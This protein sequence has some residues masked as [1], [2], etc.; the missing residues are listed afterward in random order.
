[1]DERQLYAPRITDQV[2]LLERIANGL[3]EAYRSDLE[4]ELKH[5]FSVQ[6]L[7]R[8]S[9]ADSAEDHFYELRYNENDFGIILPIQKLALI[10]NRY[11]DVDESI[12]HLAKE[13]LEKRGYSVSYEV[14]DMYNLVEIAKQKRLNREESEGELKLRELRESTHL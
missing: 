12:F 4:T 6:S 8:Y 7:T 9:W 3:S 10:G 1:M 14:D 11:V 13:I 2:D 5:P